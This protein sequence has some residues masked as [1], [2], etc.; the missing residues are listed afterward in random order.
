MNLTTPLAGLLGVAASLGAFAAPQAAD[1]GVMQFPNVTLAAQAPPEQGRAAPPGGGAMAY[2]DPATGKLTGP[3]SQQAA[4]L[5]GPPRTAATAG[6]PKPSLTRLP[7]GGVSMMLDERHQ[8]HAVAHK[9]ADGK[10]SET[11]EPAGQAGE[12]DEK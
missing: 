6:A 1:T 12:H 9:D 5:A 4:A 7:N 10:L 3:T 11:C 8:R 2:K